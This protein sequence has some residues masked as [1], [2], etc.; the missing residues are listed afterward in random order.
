[1]VPITGLLTGLSIEQFGQNYTNDDINLV[2]SG[3]GGQNATGVANVNE[4]GEVDQILITNQ[5]EF[6]ESPPLIQIIGGGGNGATAEANI[7]LGVIDEISL[8]QKGGGYVNDPQVIF[9]RDTNL[10][11]TA[12]NRQSLN[13]VM[14]NLTGLLKDVTPSE[15]TV[16]VQSTAHIQDLEN[17]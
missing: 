3:G 11:R 13:S 10:I 14:Y 5:G 1:M 12:R 15:Q 16:Y 6:F 7:N 2:I 17:F 4:F 8:L 9:T